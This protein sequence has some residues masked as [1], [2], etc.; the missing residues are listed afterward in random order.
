[1][2]TDTSE[3]SSFEA[4]LAALIVSALNLEQ[5]PAELD[6]TAPL[7]GEAGLGIDSIDALEISLTLSR[8]YGVQ[9][10]ADDEN[11]NQIFASL[12]N[13]AEYIQQHR[14]K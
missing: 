4:E 5:N 14:T 9:L 10:R 13:L 8:Q 3:K 2:I 12:R 7:Y 6:P 11:N 1:M